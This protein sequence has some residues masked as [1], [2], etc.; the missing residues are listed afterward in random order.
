MQLHGWIC[1]KGVVEAVCIDVEGGASTNEAEVALPL[2]G[3]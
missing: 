1:P 3:Q 2:L